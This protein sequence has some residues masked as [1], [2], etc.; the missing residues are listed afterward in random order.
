VLGFEHP[1]GTDAQ[2]A[3]VRK[4]AAKLRQTQGLLVPTPA[5]QC[6]LSQV[7]LVSAA[8]APELLG[9]AA[10][11]PRA[12]PDPDGHADLDASYVWT[13]A[14]PKEL[15]SLDVGLIAAFP[16]MRQINVQVISPKGQSATQLVGAT[17]TVT[18]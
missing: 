9:E 5:A 3:T 17:R 7:E 16:G 8:L 18:W 14:A 12:A 2:R 1:P 15:R 4:M 10:S 13:C 6:T 11:T